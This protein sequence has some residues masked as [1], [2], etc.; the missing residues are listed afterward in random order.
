MKIKKIISFII[1]ILFFSPCL[2][3]LFDLQNINFNNVLQLFISLKTPL[4]NTILFGTVV[5]IASTILGTSLFWIIN[6]HNF[7]FVTLFKYLIFLPAIIPIYISGYATAH[8]FSRFNIDF[9]NYFGAA[10]VAIFS[11]YPYSYMIA[12]SSTKKIQNIII[13]SRLFG[14]NSWRI[15]WKILFPSIRPTIIFSITIIFLEILAEYGMSKEYGLN[16][17]TNFVY[18]QWF[19]LHNY[20]NVAVINI[21][22][23]AIISILLIIEEKYRNKERYNL[24]LPQ[25]QKIKFYTNFKTQIFMILYCFITI[26]CGLFI[27]ISELIYLAS[28]KSNSFYNLDRLIELSKLSFNT[29]YLSSIISITTIIFGYLMYKVSSGGESFIKKVLKIF[30][31]LTYGIPGAFIS[32]NLIVCFN[33]IIRFI[34]LFSEVLAKSI[35]FTFFGSIFGI[36]YGSIF[37]FINIAISMISFRSKTQKREI[38][39]VQKIYSENRISNFFFFLPLYIR[40]LIILFLI[41][42]ID[43]VKE[44]PITIILRPFNFDNLTIKVFDF[45]ADE[46]YSEA[47]IVS[48]CLIFVLLI[49]TSFLTYL[50]NNLWKKNST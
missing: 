45:I 29:I 46:R 44:L 35:N 15:Y 27:P 22:I 40:E 1:I 42:F 33:R 17:L 38:A 43:S 4:T 41:L 25:R 19:Y 30:T 23:F 10:L 9:K 18:K 32:I 2:V 37:R 47:A 11:L 48:L 5:S 24:N 7:R 26:Y 3:F 39:L 50:T 13:T 14:Y 49:I 20:Q 21:T 12:N 34:S 6:F 36:I 8:F 31:S 16:N 28:I